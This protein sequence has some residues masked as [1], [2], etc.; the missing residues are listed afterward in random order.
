MNY[1]AGVLPISWVYTNNCW[2]C[3]FLL[4][5]DGRDHSYSDFAG[6]AER[7]DKD[8][9]ACAA[10]EFWEETYGLLIPDQKIIRARILSHSVLCMSRTQNNMPFYCYILEMPYIPGLRATFLKTVSFLRG[11]G[12]PKLYIEKTD[13]KYCT[14]DELMGSDPPKRGVFKATLDQHRAT[15]EAIVAAG[16]GGWR[17]MVSAFQT[18]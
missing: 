1:A 11:R 6:R 2:T 8:A 15:L 16:P 7:I 4:G 10:R 13:V 5:K 9:P 18:Q 14:W 17:S 3:L 12:I